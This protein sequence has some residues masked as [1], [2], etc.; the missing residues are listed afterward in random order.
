MR[1]APPR[2]I[3]IAHRPAEPSDPLRA[4]FYG[5]PSRGVNVAPGAL[6]HGACPKRSTG[7]EA[8]VLAALER[9][10]RG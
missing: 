1:L 9:A 5:R 8:A 7:K 3:I 10:F 6:G 2:S 4:A